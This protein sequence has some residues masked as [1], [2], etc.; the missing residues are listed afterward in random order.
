LITATTPVIIH[1][2]FIQTSFIVMAGG[3]HQL[4]HVGVNSWQSQ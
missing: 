1:N 2:E 4:W 3:V